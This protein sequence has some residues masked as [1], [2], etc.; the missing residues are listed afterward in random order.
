MPSVSHFI[1]S[2]G[3]V[4]ALFAA[5]RV[6]QEAPQEAVQEGARVQR[7]LV[8][9]SLFT[10]RLF[11]GEEPPELRSVRHVQIIHAD[12]IGA[13]RTV[14]RTRAEALEL[15]ANLRRA[16]LEG[17]EFE[18]L[19]RVHSSASNAAIGS[20]MGTFPPGVLYEDFDRFLFAAELGEFSAPIDA[21]T[22]VHLLQRVER[23]A[24]CLELRI[25]DTSADGE[26]RIRELHARLVA[27]ADFGALAREFSQE[28]ISAARGGALAV[29]ERGPAD[30][31]LKGEVFRLAVGELSEPLVSPLGWHVLKR[32]PI[33]VVPPELVENDWMRFR[34]LALLHAENPLGL[35]SPPRT[36]AE[37]AE[38]AR[39]IERRLKAGE[40]F[41]ELVEQFDDDFADGRARKG[42]IGW[43]HRRQPGV[44]PFMAQAFTLEVGAW[45]GPVA[46]NV[47]WVFVRREA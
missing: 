39:D 26:R 38:L 10:S 32:V 9:G 24:G 28:P 34:G 7:P 17:A 30:R 35:E 46:T 29:F 33:E 3:L 27:G 25:A 2:V 47:G 31:L 5:P 22:G 16:L 12:A 15:A 4:L 20:V 43:V 14:R 13:A 42:L 6:P 23:Q 45:L 18:A 37:A 19:A 36:S 8:Q 41:V 11:L 40:D 21:P 44:P 1:T